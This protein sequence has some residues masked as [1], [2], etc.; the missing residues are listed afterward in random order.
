M[1]IHSPF[2]KIL[3]ALPPGT[4]A[5]LEYKEILLLKVG[6]ISKRFPISYFRR[7]YT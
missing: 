6:K 2:L 7:V 3:F 5:V 1:I 4:L